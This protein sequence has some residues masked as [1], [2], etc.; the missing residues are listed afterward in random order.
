MHTCTCTRAHAHNAHT[1][2][3]THTH[4]CMH[5]HTHS[6]AY[7]AHPHNAHTYTYTHTPQTQ[8]SVVNC[9][10]T[11]FDPEN[12]VPIEGNR[13]RRSTMSPAMRRKRKAAIAGF[14]RVPRDEGGRADT[15]LVRTIILI[16][17]Q[18]GGG[19]SV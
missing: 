7:T 1:Y 4:A 5:T 10:V 15:M 19:D 9:S 16:P 12:L 11:S 14:K 13:R 8:N 18:E 6:H 3:H 17:S 2:T